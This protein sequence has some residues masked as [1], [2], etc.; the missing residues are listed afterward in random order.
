MPYQIYYLKAKLIQTSDISCGIP[1][2]D[3]SEDSL[4]IRNITGL[5]NLIYGVINLPENY[6]VQDKKLYVSVTTLK[7]EEEFPCNMLGII[8]P[9]L[10]VTDAKNRD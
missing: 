10:K 2:L 9:R 6:R 5:N 4:R 3:F 8:L 7:P 1:A